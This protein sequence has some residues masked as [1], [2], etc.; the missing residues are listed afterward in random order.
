MAARR[1]PERRHETGWAARERE[2]GGRGQRSRELARERQWGP[3]RRA[4]GDAG[5]GVVEGTGALTAATAVPAPCAGCFARMSPRMNTPTTARMPTAAEASTTI[6]PWVPVRRENGAFDGTAAKG[7][8]GVGCLTGGAES[9]GCLCSTLGAKPQTRHGLSPSRSKPHFGQA[10]VT[11]RISS[12]G[13]SHSCH[14]IDRI[15]HR[16]E[17]VID[18]KNPPDWFM[19]CGRLEF[20][21]DPR[22]DK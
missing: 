11:W 7:C 17:A 16:V 2:P 13:M 22:K 3:T 15:V 6:G 21:I 18:L 10:L 1:R 9:A 19:R 14:Y 4:G 8:R 12:S 5:T 20:K